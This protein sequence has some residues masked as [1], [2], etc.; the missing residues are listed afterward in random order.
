MSSVMIDLESIST[1]PNAVI[2]SL[3]AVKFDKNDPAV[4]MDGRVWYFDVD[5]QVALGRDVDDDTLEWWATQGDEA[6]ASSFSDD[7]RMLVEDVM[8]EFHKFCWGSK[9]YWAQGTIF[10]ITILENLLVQIEKPRPWHF[11]QIRDTRTLFD[12]GISYTYDNPVKHDP[13]SDCIAQALAVQDIFGWLKNNG[14][15]KEV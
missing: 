10:D 6:I 15:N 7:D 3:A 5:Q 12:L 14:I 9:E 8:D 4:E 13:L 11:R 1:K 2:L